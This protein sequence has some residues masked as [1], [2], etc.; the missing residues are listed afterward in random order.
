MNMQ[1]LGKIKCTAVLLFLSGICVCSCAAPVAETGYGSENSE[2]LV[3]EE[4]VLPTDRISGSESSDEEILNLETE[5]MD[6][7]ENKKKRT[8]SGL[9]PDSDYFGLGDYCVEPVIATEEASEQEIEKLELFLD[10]HQE[11]LREIAI[12]S[13]WKPEI[14]LMDV[15]G[16]DVPEIQIW[17]LSNKDQNPSQYCSS[18]FDTYSGYG[19][20]F[21]LE[22]GEPMGELKGSRPDEMG[23]YEDSEGNRTFYSVEAKFTRT[24]TGGV[25]SYSYI[26]WKID[27]S[28]GRIECI[29]EWM[30]LLQRVFSEEPN[31]EECFSL[32]NPDLE[33]LNEFRDYSTCDVDKLKEQATEGMAE[34]IKAFWK[35]VKAIPTK[36]YEYGYIDTSGEIVY[37]PET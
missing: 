12:Y 35:S 6:N 33:L 32:L 34:P 20:V 27:S 7:D 2:T 15:T 10:A 28:T 3:S 8:G 26:L 18:L 16:D 36:Q 24:G 17:H 11:E 13:I 9:Q 25:Y 22:T 29:P 5:A 23:W 31:T 14:I 19:H 37:K 21:S 30:Y 1:L 4:E